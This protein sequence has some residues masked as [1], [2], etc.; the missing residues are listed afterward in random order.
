MATRNLSDAYFTVEYVEGFLHTF[1][2]APTDYG[3][4]LNHVPETNRGARS[5]ES[6]FDLAKRLESCA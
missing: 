3:Y 6:S 1:S 5:I 2:A 4:A